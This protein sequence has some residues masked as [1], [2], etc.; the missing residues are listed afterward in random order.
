MLAITPSP[1]HIWPKFAG[2]GWLGKLLK[3]QA[4]PAPDP[5]ILAP[6]SGGPT[7][8]AAIC[9]PLAMRHIRLEFVASP[10][11]SGGGQAKG[12]KLDISAQTGPGYC[13]SKGHAL[14]KISPKPVEVLNSPTIGAPDPTGTLRREGFAKGQY[15]FYAD[16]IVSEGFFGGFVAPF[17]FALALWQRSDL[18]KT[19][20]VSLETCGNRNAPKAVGALTADIV[21]YPEALLTIEVTIPAKAEPATFYEKS[22]KAA[23]ALNRQTGSDGSVFSST[24]VQTSSTSINRTPFAG[25]D[26]NGI[27]NT[28]SFSQTTNTTGRL[29]TPAGGNTSFTQ[30]STVKGQEVNLKLEDGSSGYISGTTTTNRF[31]ATG[32]NAGS[33]SGETTVLGETLIPGEAPPGF[34]EQLGLKLTYNHTTIGGDLKTWRERILIAK[35][36][37]E[38]LPR[39]ANMLN[40]KVQVGWGFKGTIT[41]PS[42]SIKLVWGLKSSTTRMRVERY[43]GI[44]GSATIV[45]AGVELSFGF[46]LAFGEALDRMGKKTS[47]ELV[48]ARVIGSLTGTVSL[49]GE[50]EELANVDKYGKVQLTGDVTVKL[51]G[52]LHALKAVYI[53]ASVTGG[54]LITGGYEASLEEGPTL[55]ITA[56]FKKLVATANIFAMGH[57]FW[58]AGPRVLMPETEPFFEMDFLKA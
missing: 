17:Q 34:A 53:D 13:G 51:Q 54:L 45:S 1:S 48:D 39:L 12:A 25:R 29:S 22:G 3:E 19:Y 38:N 58:T 42:G 35:I 10:A 43:F 21:V 30:S 7:A 20:H 18:G 47:A 6:L 52:K 36:L 32:T 55:G 33:Q 11:P 16:N 23:V 5:V 31:D 14:L 8:P 40:S 24:S 2:L 50:Y 27:R 41:G 57:E 49:V 15:V 37:L 56:G 46:K 44:L 28:G 26:A 9:G 4:K